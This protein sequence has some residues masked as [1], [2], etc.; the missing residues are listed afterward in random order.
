MAFR[1]KLDPDAFEYPEREV[2][3]VPPMDGTGDPDLEQIRTDLGYFYADII[4]VTSFVEPFWEE[5][6]HAGGSIRYIL[7]GTGYFDVRDLDDNWVRFAAKKGHFMELPSG[8]NHRFSVD[9]GQFIT[10]MRL[11][12]GDPVWTAYPRAQVLGNL[13]ARNEYVETFLCNVDPD[14]PE[15]KP[16]DIHKKKPEEMPEKK[17]EEFQ[18]MNTGTGATD[19]SESIQKFTTVGILCG[20]MTLNLLHLL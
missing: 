8:M 19:S 5:H 9:E 3:W 2:P 6:H 16:D 13:T 11:F 7:N 20:F 10:A 4:T 1:F 15:E 12:A 14:L 17:P 18:D